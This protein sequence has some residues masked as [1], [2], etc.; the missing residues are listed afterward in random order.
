MQADLT[1]TTHSDSFL[2]DLSLSVDFELMPKTN[3]EFQLGHPRVPTER[4]Q[5]N[6]TR[7]STSRCKLLDRL[8]VF[9][10]RVETSRREIT[11]GQSPLSFSTML[12][13]E[14]GF[15]VYPQ[16]AFFMTSKV[17]NFVIQDWPQVSYGV[18]SL[19]DWV[20]PINYPSTDWQPEVYLSS[21][22]GL[23]LVTST[24]RVGLTWDY[25]VKLPFALIDDLSVDK[26]WLRIKAAWSTEVAALKESNYSYH[27]HRLNFTIELSG[28]TG[29]RRLKNLTRAYSKVKLLESTFRICDSQIGHSLFIMRPVSRIGLSPSAFNLYTWETCLATRRE[30]RSCRTEALCAGTESTSQRIKDNLYA[31]SARSKSGSP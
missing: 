27:L 8:S 18:L 31:S 23:R 24:F 22:S 20:R 6:L 5:K 17:Q 26:R 4:R 1:S 12:E 19:Q 9:L 2:V 15:K 16:S 7:L 25:P 11:R 14:S 13:I 30:T 28:S 29:R 21:G 3:T 10:K